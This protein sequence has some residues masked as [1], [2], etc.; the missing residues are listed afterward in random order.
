[1]LE[2]DGLQT[3]EE[4]TGLRKILP[5]NIS[6]QISRRFSQPGADTTVFCSGVFWC[7]LLVFILPLPLLGILMILAGQPNLAICPHSMLPTWLMVAGSSILLFCFL[8]IIMCIRFC[9][10]NNVQHDEN[11]RPQSCT[12]WLISIDILFGMVWY[13]FGCYWTWTSV[14]VTMFIN[15]KRSQGYEDELWFSEALD[16]ACVGPV[17]WFSFLGTTLPF[18]YVIISI[19]LACVAK[20]RGS[21]EYLV[22]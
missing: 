2:D 6:N 15:S 8:S 22:K 19:C 10:K 16:E 7:V 1:M 9:I 12:A 18:L 14:N 20:K 3:Y 17:L 13:G 11:S 4:G 21:E 5:H